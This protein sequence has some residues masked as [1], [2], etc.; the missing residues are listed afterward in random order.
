MINWN[1]GSDIQICFNTGAMNQ[2]QQS[3][4]TY[5]SNTATMNPNLLNINGSY[6]YNYGSDTAGS[7]SKFIT[8]DIIESPVTIEGII[9]GVVR[10]SYTYTIVQSSGNVPIPSLAPAD[11]KYEA[12]GKTPICPVQGIPG[13]HIIGGGK[14]VCGNGYKACGGWLDACG[15]PGIILS[16]V[17]SYQNCPDYNSDNA[18]SAPRAG[19]STTSGGFAKGDVNS[20]GKV[21]MA[22]IWI[23]FDNYRSANSV[24]DVNGDGKV[25][26]FDYNMLVGNFGK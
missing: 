9:D 17:P 22:D 2:T 14:P 7:G 6:C 18:A 1:S 24:V 10:C 11:C 8:L 15:C 23:F 4:P 26:I 12:D 19:G 16:C 5:M 13:S 25:D 20:D 3:N 21:N